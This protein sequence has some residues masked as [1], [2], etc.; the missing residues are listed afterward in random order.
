M[1]S[2]NVEI[3]KINTLLDSTLNNSQISVRDL[4]K[5]F[6]SK[7]TKRRT[8]QIERMKLNVSNVEEELKQTVAGK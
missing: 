4:N 8:E 1:V 3:P 7:K 5:Q 2:L 6:G